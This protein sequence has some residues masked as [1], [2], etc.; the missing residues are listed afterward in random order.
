MLKLFD[1]FLHQITL[2]ILA[3][4]GHEELKQIG[5]NAYGHR[6]KLL[7]GIEKLYTGHSEYQFLCYFKIYNISSTSKPVKTLFLGYN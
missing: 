7:K 3:E 5:V 1:I 2:D 4:M 6:H